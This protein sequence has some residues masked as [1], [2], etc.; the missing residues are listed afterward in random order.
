MSAYCK[1]SDI[2]DKYKKYLNSI[3]S[4][5]DEKDFGKWS[6]NLHT[7]HHEVDQQW[8]DIL[9]VPKCE[10]DYT[11][12][13]CAKRI[14]PA[15]FERTK[16]ATYR[17]LRDKTFKSIEFRMR[18]HDGYWIW[19]ENF[20]GVCEYDGKNRPVAVSGILRNITREKISR[21]N[22]Q[23]NE[24]RFRELLDKLP[25][26]AVQGYDRHRRI[27]YWNKASEKLYGYTK[28]EVW[29]RKIEDLIIPLSMREDVINSIK[30]WIEKGIVIEP[31]EL[32]LMRKDG[33]SITVFS[34][35]ILLDE[36]DGNPTLFCIDVDLTKEKIAQNRLEWLASFDTLTQ[37][38]NRQQF[39]NYIDRLINESSRMDRCFSLSFID[40]DNFKII[41]DS[42][43][44]D[45]GDSLL[46]QVVLRIRNIL[47]SYDFFAR[48]GGDEFILL[49]PY[50][51]IE[52]NT[53][54]FEKIINI[55]Q[56]PFYIDK[57]ELH[58]SC[59]IGVSLFPENG[60]ERHTLLRHADTAMYKA[61]TLGKNRFVFF[62]NALNSIIQKQLKMQTLIR[63]A[64]KHN[65]FQL[66]YQP[67]VDA[68]SEQIVYLE[69]LIRLKASDGEIILP[70][71]FIPFAE[72]SILIDKIGKWV[73]NEVCKTLRQ[74]QDIGLSP[75][76]KINIS[77]HTF[78]FFNLD[79]QIAKMLDKYNISAEQLGIE[80]TE[81]TL[82]DNYEEAIKIIRNLKK[83]G[84][85][86]SIDDFGTGYSSISYLKKFPLD[87][88]KID[89]SF[90]RN[91]T[92]EE[93]DKKLVS[94]IIAI[95]K[96]LNLK[97]IAEGVETKEQLD[98][99]R[100]VDC[101]YIQGYYFY[102]PM[103]SKKIIE[104]MN[105]AKTD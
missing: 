84:I 4:F 90:I 57:H 105:A 78:S 9:G 72:K 70:D 75:K 93:T 35:H 64:L 87:F 6:L 37:L 94:A 80:I 40:L 77:G 76:V 16:A 46:Q 45:V 88:I 103:S 83:T 18:H 66:Y 47:R 3:S 19:V 20:G 36:E 27:I 34:D 62:S 5:F 99:L 73:I 100:L 63:E 91:I 102:K 86:I 17:I 82:I 69:A 25:N 67:I 71:N 53:A 89:R 97:V 38:P 12:D 23:K 8:L 48:F 30:N 22:I 59:S 24:K 50:N 92:T 52:D 56:T 95:G 39:V 68:N 51:H 101:D 61:K 14:H 11:E 49:S 98:Y 29:D 42:F 96:S 2:L 65:R 31:S 81:D 28:E 54:L 32:T 1:E 58:I 43:G 21:V 7:K 33:S 74:W 85:N 44:H 41:N 13:D 55:L 60:E 10:L 26:I 15:D 104:L 79:D